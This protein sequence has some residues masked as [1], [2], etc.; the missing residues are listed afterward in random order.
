MTRINVGVCPSELQDKHLIAEH[1]EIKRIPNLIVKGKYN[2][3]NT[4]PK[5]TLGKGHVAFFYNKVNYLYSRYQA[6]Y[7][8]CKSRGF[9]VQYYG[10]C[11]LTVPSELFNN[12][13]ETSAD[14]ALLI[15]RISQRGGLKSKA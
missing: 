5:F 3:K 12:Y 10:D 14:R 11:F 9:N 1:R 15:E 2:L 4:P 7:Q 8:E 6:L 13:S